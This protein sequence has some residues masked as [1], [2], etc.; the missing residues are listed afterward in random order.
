MIGSLDNPPLVIRARRVG[1]PFR[2]MV[3]FAVPLALGAA[4]AAALQDVLEPGHESISVWVVVVAWFALSLYGLV[5]AVWLVVAPAR[6]I[7]SPD[8]LS[9]RILWRTLRWRW[10]DVSGFRKIRYRGAYWV[11]FDVAN[12][13]AINRVRTAT[14]ADFLLL[15]SRLAHDVDGQ[16][17]LFAAAR[18][19]WKTTDAREDVKTEAPAPP[20][21]SLAWRLIL[22]RIN[23]RTYWVCIFIAL[24]AGLALAELVGADETSIPVGV[25]VALFMVPA[26]LAAIAVRAR[27]RDLGIRYWQAR[28]VTGAVA[29]VG[30]GIALAAHV[31]AKWIAFAGLAL[32]AAALLALGVLPGQPKTNRFGAAP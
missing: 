29:I 11:G 23:R 18:E 26:L 1:N 4:A 19:R 10:S 13:A 28:L 32:L 27:S 20:H 8:G 2:T 25:F 7:L 31:D 6:A 22:G 3:G 16:A 24:A 15:N 17:P 14:G 5:I 12:P 30:V 9:Y 21:R